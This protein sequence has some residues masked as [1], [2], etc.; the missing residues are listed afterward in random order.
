MLSRLSTGVRSSSRT[1][2]G[3]TAISSSASSR[4]ASRIAPRLAATGA[5]TTPIFRS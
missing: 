1:I 3:R 2:G 4:S 5:I